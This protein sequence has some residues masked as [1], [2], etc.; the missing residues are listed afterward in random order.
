MFTLI[1]V[2]YPMRSAITLYLIILILIY[3][4][5]PNLWKQFNNDESNQN[6]YVLPIIIMIISIISYY[7]FLTLNSFFYSS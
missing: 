2:E 1:N 5:R 3:F 6:K 7:I 4:F